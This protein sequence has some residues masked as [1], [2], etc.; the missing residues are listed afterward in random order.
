M[1]NKHD[2]LVLVKSPQ[3]HINGVHGWIVKWLYQKQAI[4]K[5][6]ARTRD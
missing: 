2:I 1:T 3:D 6:V 4:A 5:A